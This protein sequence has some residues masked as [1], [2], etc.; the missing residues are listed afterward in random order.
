MR[1]NFLFLAGLCGLIILGAA[2]LFV[3]R[4]LFADQQGLQDVFSII[5]SAALCVALY[6]LM[7]AV[8]RPA[9]GEKAGWQHTAYR[10]FRFITE[11]VAVVGLVLAA[12][13]ASVV[14]T[15]E[16]SNTQM[17]LAAG[18]VGG[19]GLALLITPRVMRLLNRRTGRLEKQPES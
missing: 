14:L 10:S 13:V 4:L 7:R 19:S 15:S 12:V 18:F 9:K 8:W 17:V 11:L 2:T 16:G 1:A 5:W 6:K 3:N